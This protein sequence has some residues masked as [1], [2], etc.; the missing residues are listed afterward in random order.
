MC[1]FLSPSFCVSLLHTVLFKCTFGVRCGVYNLPTTRQ[2]EQPTRATFSL[3][4][5]SPTLSKNTHNPH[6]NFPSAPSAQLAVRRA[7]RSVLI[8]HS[9]CQPSDNTVRTF[10]MSASNCWI[11]IYRSPLG[12]YTSDCACIIG[13]D[14]LFF[15]PP[16]SY[17]CVACPIID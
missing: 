2:S 11:H 15:L 12:T 8:F 3:V 7:K 4:A 6:S 14:F 1:V 13:H 9:K 10:P 16:H 17:R 5:L